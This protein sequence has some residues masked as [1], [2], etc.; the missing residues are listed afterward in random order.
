MTKN[1]NFGKA[2]VM[3][4]ILSIVFLPADLRAQNRNQTEASAPK[5]NTST[6]STT[7]GTSTD[8]TAK[9]STVD[10]K[11]TELKMG[12]WV[13]FEDDIG[14]IRILLV[15]SKDDPKKLARIDATIGD[16][17]KN[18]EV[19][20]VGNAVVFNDGPRGKYYLIK[21]TTAAGE[22]DFVFQ[23]PW[24]GGTACNRSIEYVYEALSNIPS[25][26]GFGRNFS[27]TFK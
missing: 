6:Q 16:P 27:F 3:L 21:G 5:N 24:G 2:F 22:E 7:T 18:G 4:T 20:L 13:S 25:E 23:V 17:G 10:T 11:T 8:S 12:E 14:K 1:M 15:P 26:K 19:N 9:A